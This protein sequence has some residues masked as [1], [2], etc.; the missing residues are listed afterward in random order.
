MFSASTLRDSVFRPSRPSSSTALHPTSSL[1]VPTLEPTSGS[2]SCGPVPCMCHSV[3]TANIQY[4]QLTSCYF[5]SGAACE[6]AREGIPAAAFS[7]ASGSQ[8]SYTTLESDPTST[9]TLAAQIYSNLTADFVKAVTSTPG[10]FLPPGVIANVKMNTLNYLQTPVISLS[11]GLPWVLRQFTVPIFASS[12][13]IAHSFIQK[14]MCLFTF[15]IQRV[16]PRLLVLRRSV[17][18]TVGFTA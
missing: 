10:P 4:N 7:G 8:V 15:N 16:S 9:S 14:S 6:A 5:R 2:S 12:T 13:L 18:S 11:R 3:L 1:A 17:Y